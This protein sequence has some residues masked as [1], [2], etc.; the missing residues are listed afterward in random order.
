[1]DFK[2]LDQKIKLNKSGRIDKIAYCSNFS[3]NHSES[4]LMKQILRQIA[5]NFNYLIVKFDTM[6]MEDIVIEIRK[7]CIK[8]FECGFTKF[9]SNSIYVID[10]IEKKKRLEAKSKLMYISNQLWLFLNNNKSS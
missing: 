10:Y 2:E 9:N 5:I 4:D 7:N 3:L 8:N 1:M 6:R